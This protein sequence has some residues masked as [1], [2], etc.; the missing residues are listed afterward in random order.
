MACRRM[1]Q[2]CVPWPLGRT[3]CVA[4]SWPLPW[5]TTKL[6]AGLAGAGTAAGACHCHSTRDATQDPRAIWRAP[7]T[8]ISR[9]P[10]AATY[11]DM[12]SVRTVAVALSTFVE[13]TSTSLAA[14]DMNTT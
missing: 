12:L 6:T 14:S 9:K 10:H 11:A 7:P 5:A 3:L 4:L 8:G 1:T 2:G 13:K